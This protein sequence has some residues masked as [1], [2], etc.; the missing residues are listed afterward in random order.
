LRAV[1]DDLAATGT[2]AR[3][4]AVHIQEIV[5]ETQQSIRGQMADVRH[6][7]LDTMRE[8]RGTLMRP[9]RHYAAIASGI[10]EGL[11]TF[12]FGRRQ[13]EDAKIR[14]EKQHPAA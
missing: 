6:V 8:A 12:L 9:I 14:V 11:R 13:T 1:A 2:I 10:A 4:Q 7:I 5:T 3:Q